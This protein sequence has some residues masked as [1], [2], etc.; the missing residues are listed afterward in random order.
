MIFPKCSPNMF[1]SS[2]TSFP[3][4]CGMTILV[5]AHGRFIFN[6]GSSRARAILLAIDYARVFRRRCIGVNVGRIPH[7]RA[8]QRHHW[9]YSLRLDPLLLLGL[10]THLHLQC[11]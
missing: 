7:M 4:I 5:F 3:M 2:I 1:K 10:I 8:F 9:C 6:V 11:F